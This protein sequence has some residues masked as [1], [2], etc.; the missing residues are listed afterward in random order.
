[1]RMVVFSSAFISLSFFRRAVPAAES[2][3]PV[4]SSAKR[5]DGFFAKALA[6]A[7]LWRCPPESCAGYLSEKRSDAKALCQFCNHCVNFVNRGA[8][9]RKRH[10]DV[11]LHRQAVEQEIFLKDKA[12]RSRRKSAAALSLRP[13]ISIP[14]KVMRP[15]VGVSIVDRTLSRVVFP[16]PDAPIMPTNSPEATLNETL[17]RAGRWF[18]IIIF[19]QILHIQ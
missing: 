4:G 3:A 10:G 14:P 17:S 18:F 13:C 15:S 6:A 8:D 9:E 19:G 5:M 7:V 11:L 12:R 16:E 2:R 1:M